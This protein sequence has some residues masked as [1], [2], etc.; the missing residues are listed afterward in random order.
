MAARA[1]LRD[2]N[3]KVYEL[4][5]IFNISLS[6]MARILGVDEKAA[7]RLLAVCDLFKT[8]P[9]FITNLLNQHDLPIT[10]ESAAKMLGVTVPTIASNH[11]PDA[12]LQIGERRCLY[13][14][15]LRRF[16]KLAN[17]RKTVTP[18]EEAV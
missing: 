1:H 16:E 2:R 15:S 13:A 11:E 5:R 9:E 14:Y 6:H 3:V 12:V 8:T 7:V 10:R 4:A 18:V 17:A